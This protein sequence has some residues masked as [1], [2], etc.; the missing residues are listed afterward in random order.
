MKRTR[1]VI[2]VIACFAIA[3]ILISISIYF[4]Y[5]NAYDTGVMQYTVRFLGIP[6]YE[7]TKSEAEY[8]GSAV[9]K[10]LNMGIIC[11]FFAIAGFAAERLIFKIKHK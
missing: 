1:T 5:Y 11:G 8:F 6:I 9:N 3:V 4:G 7:L 10:G 2:T